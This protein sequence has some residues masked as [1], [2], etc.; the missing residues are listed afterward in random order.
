MFQRREQCRTGA[1]V[2]SLVEQIDMTRSE[3]VKTRFQYR[4][5][6][7]DVMLISLAAVQTIKGNIP[8]MA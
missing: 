8:Q 3:D 5:T 7:L 2:I 1:V 6:L 4:Y